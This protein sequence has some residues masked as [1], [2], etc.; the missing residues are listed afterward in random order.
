[1]IQTLAVSIEASQHVLVERIKERIAE[2]I[3]DFLVVPQMRREIVD[4]I[5]PAPVERIKHRVTRQMVGCP[6]CLQSWKKLW[7]LYR[8]W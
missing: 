7:K 4:V 5:Q 6:W 2:Q 1:M 3:V 8:K